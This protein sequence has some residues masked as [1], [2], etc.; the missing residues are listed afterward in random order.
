MYSILFIVIIIAAIGGGAFLYQ[1]NTAPVGQ[2]KPSAGKP[3]RSVFDGSIIDKSGQSL[4][5]IDASFFQSNRDITVLDLSNNSLTGALPAEIRHL[6]R[7]RELR[8][9][10]N[11]MTGVPA[12]I[13]QL[14]NLEV[15]D[16]SNNAITGLPYELGNLKRLRVF[17]LKGNP[18]SQ[19][20]LDRI[21]QGIP[22]ATIIT[23]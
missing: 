8:A 23:N 18:F 20:D 7:L 3:T 17:N 10:N 19:Q 22:Q 5:R 9:S 16:L 21:R 1:V 15:L 4:T 6:S 14:S 2:P 11:A 13:G 12:E